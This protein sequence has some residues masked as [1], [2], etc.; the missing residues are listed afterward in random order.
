MSANP[1][2]NVIP[3]AILLYVGFSFIHNILLFDIDLDFIVVAC[4]G[5]HQK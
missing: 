4:S 2:I 1:A 5:P 3:L